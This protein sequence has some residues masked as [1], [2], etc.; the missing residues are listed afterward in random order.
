MTLRVEAAAWV[1]ALSI[2]LGMAVSCERAGADEGI[3]SPSP[4]AAL[5]WRADLG[6][7]LAYAK[8][9]RLPVL[10]DFTAEWCAPCQEL[11]EK[12]FPDASLRTMLDEENFVLIKQDGSDS[13]EP[14]QA[15]M[16][17]F[18]VESFPTLIIIDR[19]GAV[20]GRTEDFVTPEA[21][22]EELRNA[23][24]QP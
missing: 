2:T 19:F 8:S 23:V 14:I 20:V 5:T 17:R 22:L 3:E 10:I 4:V 15:A 24:P 21:L 11:E 9:N 16:D 1:V 12:T 13:V 6:P 7:A 18:G